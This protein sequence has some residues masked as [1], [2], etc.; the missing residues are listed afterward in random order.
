M[1]KY[2]TVVGGVVA[3]AGGFWGLVVTWPLLLRMLEVSV[4]LILL[5]GG[6]FAVAIGAA[7]IRDRWSAPR[8]PPSKPL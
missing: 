8:T 7:E 2:L 3:I 4:P 5:V 6:M 1:G